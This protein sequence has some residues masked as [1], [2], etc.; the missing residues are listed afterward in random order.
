M[1]SKR[2]KTGSFGNQYCVVEFAGGRLSMVRF[3]QTCIEQFEVRCIW[4]YTGA[5]RVH[6]KQRI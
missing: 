4:E 2:R 6:E 3:L 1:E 5:G